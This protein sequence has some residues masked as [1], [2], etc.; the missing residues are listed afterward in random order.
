MASFSNLEPTPIGRRD[1][2][3]FAGI[4]VVAALI[5]FYR[6]FHFPFA[7]DDYT[8]L[9][10]VSGIEPARPVLRRVLA[11]RLYYLAMLR[12][13]G[14]HP[15]PWHVVAFVIHVANAT[16]VGAF[17]RRFGATRYSAG[18]ASAL[19]AA[20]PVNFTVLYWVAC[21]QELGAT[22]LL[23]VAAWM[24]AWNGSRAWWAVPVFAAAMLFKESVLVMPVALALLYGRRAWRPAGAML[25]VGIAIFVGS[26]L[27]AR[28]FASDLALPYS[29]SY[30]SN[31]VV[32][33]ATQLF[34]FFGVWRAYPDRI[35]SPDRG[36]VLPALAF[37][38]LVFVVAWRMGPSARRA[39]GLAAAWC[40]GA[41][42]PI[43]PLSQHAYA[44][45]M[46]TP[47]I[48]LVIVLAAAIERL[49]LRSGERDLRVRAA[50]VVLV[51]APWIFSAVR[52]TRTH[53]MLTLPK[54]QVP[55]D[56]IVRSARAA[57]SLV[58][59]VEHLPESVHRVAFMMYPEQVATAA[60]TPGPTGPNL[61]VRRSYPV[62]DAYRDGKLFQLHVPRLASAWLDT[63]TEAD[64]RSDNAVFFL[65]GFDRITRL[66]DVGHAYRLQAEGQLMIH[67]NAA[68]MR[69][70][71]RAL[72]IEPTN[73]E[74]R[75]YMAG[76]DL[77]SGDVAASRRHVAGITPADLPSD[78]RPLLGEIHRALG[79]V[80]SIATSK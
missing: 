8:Y 42:L 37:V 57:G 74:V 68:A 62:R 34:W 38:I 51:I 33:L 30:G 43:L 64:E 24:L 44:Y 35:A 70:L 29:T 6:S 19:F 79:A 54:S 31:L 77:E 39:A 78:L 69:S 26:G 11:T 59:A 27:H 16:M 15:T 71:K 63:L 46:Y 75:L 53:E 3:L 49:I 18:L 65:S 10:Q 21:I 36:A 1:L 23:L 58:A 9:M 7:L 25:A 17:A 32:H 73:A 80:D 2:A 48:G 40:V 41:L 72:D 55:H 56:S 47:Q 4:A 20:S 14:P 76:L 60:R 45:Y 61:V 22:A 50:A 5:P 28:M 12:L 67:D 66:E 13:F 52:T